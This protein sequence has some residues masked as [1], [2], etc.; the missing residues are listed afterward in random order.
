[1]ILTFDPENRLKIYSSKTDKNNARFRGFTPE[2][3]KK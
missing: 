1:M 3:Q 2:S